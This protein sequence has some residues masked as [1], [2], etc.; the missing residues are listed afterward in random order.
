MQEHE[1]SLALLGFG[2]AES[3][4]K[5]TS[6]VSGWPDWMEL[7]SSFPPSLAAPLCPERVRKCD[8][9]IGW[10]LRTKAF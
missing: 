1:V 6:R 4:G 8:P 3:M 10:G 2:S 9:D 5:V 7:L